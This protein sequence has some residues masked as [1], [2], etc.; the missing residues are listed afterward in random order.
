MTPSD[1]PRVPVLFGPTTLAGPQDAVLLDA[2]QPAPAQAGVVV[3]LAAAAP[4]TAFAHG[5]FCACCRPRDAAAQVL[6]RLA[7]SRGRGEVALFRRLVVAVVDP[8]PVRAA[9]LEDRLA[10]GH[11]RLAEGQ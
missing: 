6:G 9:V 8:A 10:A 2:A 7:L 3:R 5:A 4:A 1:D 11:Y